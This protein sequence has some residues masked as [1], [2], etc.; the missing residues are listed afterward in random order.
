[1]AKPRVF[2]RAAVDDPKL[3]RIFQQ[4]DD[5]FSNLYHDLATQAGVTGPTGPSITGPT[6]PTGGDGPTGPTGPGGGFDV[7]LFWSRTDDAETA[8]GR[9]DALGPGDV[10]T[11]VVPVGSGGDWNSH[12]NEF[13]TWDWD[14]WSWT[15]QSPDNGNAVTRW[16]PP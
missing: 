6:G 9:L 2:K 12:D 3:N 4:I 15:F 8:W 14:T 11:W 7:T 13:A 5:E 16:T 10:V 1:M